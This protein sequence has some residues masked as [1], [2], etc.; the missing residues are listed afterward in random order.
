MTCAW[1]GLLKFVT[2]VISL[3]ISL[4]IQCNVNQTSVTDGE[5]VVV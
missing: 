5:W 1:L 3:Q 4:L 2:V